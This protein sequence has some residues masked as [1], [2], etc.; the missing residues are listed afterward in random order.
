MERRQNP[1]Y[2]MPL[3][4]LAEAMQKRAGELQGRRERSPEERLALADDTAMMILVAAATLSPGHH[5]AGEPE[6]AMDA[7]PGFAVAFARWH[8]QAARGARYR[9]LVRAASAAL[10]ARMQVWIRDG[11]VGG[12]R[13]YDL[14]LASDEGLRLVLQELERQRGER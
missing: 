13:A 7:P 1:Y 8:E 2:G 12:E 11:R 14:A 4:D 10:G 5:A 9:T 3:E 6:R